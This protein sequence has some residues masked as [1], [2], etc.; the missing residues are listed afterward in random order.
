MLVPWR[1]MSDNSFLSA[2]KPLRFV[3]KISRDFRNPWRH[4]VRS[5]RSSSTTHSTRAD[6]R[7]LRVGAS[8]CR[9]FQRPNDVFFEWTTHVIQ[10]SVHF[11]HMFSGCLGLMHHS[12][13]KTDFP[14]LP[15]SWT[16]P[17]WFQRLLTAMPTTWPTRCRAQG[18]SLRWW[19][20]QSPQQHQHRNAWCSCNKSWHVLRSPLQRHRI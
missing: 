5:G 4:L 7:L 8:K 15:E 16:S 19:W 1:V 11:C 13:Q 9:N 6:H 17:P 18:N 12:A 3:D 2:L 20:C 14:S 10:M